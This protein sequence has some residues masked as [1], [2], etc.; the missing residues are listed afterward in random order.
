MNLRRPAA[1]GRRAAPDSGGFEVKGQLLGG[2]ELLV[3]LAHRH[4]VYVSGATPRGGPDDAL[5][6]V[7]LLDYRTDRAAHADAVAVPMVMRIFFAIGTERVELE[8]VANL[9][10]SWK[11]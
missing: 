6:V 7:A 4:D 2:N 11:M 10:P 5:L 8:R 9:R 1:A 3:T